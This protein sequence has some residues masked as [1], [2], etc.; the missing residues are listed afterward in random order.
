MNLEDA[1]EMNLILP[2]I[3][4]SE[5]CLYLNIYTPT[6]AQEGSNLPVSVRLAPL[7]TGHLFLW[8]MGRNK[9]ILS[10]TVV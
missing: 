4:M 2:P 10:S 5:D 7:G 3:S 6:H 1:K 8:K 9:I